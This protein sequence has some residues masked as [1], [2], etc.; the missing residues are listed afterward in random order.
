MIRDPSDG[1]VREKPVIGKSP[2][3]ENQMA[4]EI[5]VNPLIAEINAALLAGKVKPER[6]SQEWAFQRAWN[7]GID[8]SLRQ[9]KRIAEKG[10]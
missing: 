2:I 8:F 7:E 4:G 6:V 5:P 3:T 1:S 9:I 10:K